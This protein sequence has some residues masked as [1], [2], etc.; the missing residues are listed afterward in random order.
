MAT[1][2]VTG[3][4]G[5]I[6]SNFIRYWLAN[7]P[8]D[9]VVNY[10]LPTEAGNP[11]NV[12]DCAGNP[13]YAYV[14][15][16]ISDF[17]AVA[18]LLEEHRPDCIVNFA[19]ESHNSRAVQDP[20]IFFR[21]NAVGTQTLLE[22]A[23][24][25]RV[26]RFH[27]ISTC[28]VYGDLALDSPDR[29][30]ED[31]PLLPNTPYNASKAAADLA[32]RAYSR[33]FGLPVTV[34]MCGNNY[35]PYQHPE[36][37]IPHFTTRLIDGRKIPLYK[38]S[39]HMREWMHVDD[40]CRALDLILGKAQAGSRH[41]VGSGH[42]ESVESIADSLLAIFGLDQ[43]YKQYVPDRPG[44]DRRYLL[45]SSSFCREFGWETRIGFA[46]GLAAA[47]E[48][49]REHEKWWRPLVERLAVDESG[50]GKS[51]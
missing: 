44:H 6:G 46:E 35:G 31:S 4:Y 21:T 11:E 37:L 32:V 40:H 27:H 14:S 15:G 20:G 50:W 34:S 41:N 13:S 26:A 23:R 24:Q 29:F 5:F 33:T 42:E 18:S 16:S 3:G 10:D 8:D 43:S 7:H 36:K 25:F 30:S 22:G 38:S 9:R 47:V 19:A 1:I 45:D 28:E 49:Y 51:G 39:M 48:W 17:K 12:A 2:I